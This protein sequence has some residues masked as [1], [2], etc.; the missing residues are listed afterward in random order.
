[1]FWSLEFNKF[2]EI[3]DEISNLKRFHSNPSCLIERYL[4]SKV[5]NIAIFMKKILFWKAC[6]HYYRSEV[7]FNHLFATIKDLA[8]REKPHLSSLIIKKWIKPHKHTTHFVEITHVEF[9]MKE[10][11]ECRSD[12][13][14]LIPQAKLD[15]Q[16]WNF[17]KISKT[18]SSRA[19]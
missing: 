10:N 2:M 11:S 15:E 6:T 18:L 13:P 4:W 7:R 3:K 1:M 5:C 8:R 12:T 9:Y 14:R 17:Q 16:S 19:P